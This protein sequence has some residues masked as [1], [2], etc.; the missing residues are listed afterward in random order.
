MIEGIGSTNN[1]DVH[2]ATKSNSEL[3]KDAFLKLMIAQLQNQDPLEPLDGT[4]YSAQLAQFSSLEQMQN[5]NETLN[6]SLD[7]NYLLTQ[8]ITNTMTASLIGKEAKIAGDT[9]KYEG[10][11]ETN[12]G[13]DLIAPAHSLEIKIVDKNGATVKTFDDPDKSEGQ[14][15]LTWDFTDDNGNKVNVGDYKVVI[16][17]KTRGLQPMEVAQYFVGI[18][19]GVRYSGNGTSIVVNDLEYLVA[20]V[21]EIVQAGNGDNSEDVEV[22]DQNIADVIKEYSGLV[23]EGKDKTGHKIKGY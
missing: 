9:V 15:K 10:Q 8:S 14:H 7:A 19:N 18:I 22:V 12:I 1:S 4:D 21:F 13:Y 3:D 16:N 6:M 5:I 23:K 17:A 20:D 2:Y 11:A